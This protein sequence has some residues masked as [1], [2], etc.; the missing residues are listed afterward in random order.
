MGHEV[1]SY[2]HP[3]DHLLC[4][5][6]FLNGSIGRLLSPVLDMAPALVAKLPLLH[7]FWQL[8]SAL[9]APVICVSLG[10]SFVCRVLRVGARG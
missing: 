4:F 3:L 1:S 7:L 5:G 9:F 8:S 2:L 10:L 6:F